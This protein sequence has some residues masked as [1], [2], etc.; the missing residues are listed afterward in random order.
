MK[1]MVRDGLYYVNP[2]GTITTDL[3]G[4]IDFDRK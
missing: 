2:D 4:W 1:K 3:Q